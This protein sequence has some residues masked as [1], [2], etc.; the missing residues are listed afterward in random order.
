MLF[1][2]FLFRLFFANFIVYFFIK[3]NK[4]KI[5]NIQHKCSNYF[6][7]IKLKILFIYFL[8]NFYFNSHIER[9]FF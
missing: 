3:I 8:I 9:L 6:F 4:N 7:K 2:T 1:L 5:Q